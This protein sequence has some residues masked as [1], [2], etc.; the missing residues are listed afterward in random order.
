M[1]PTNAIPHPLRINPHVF[2]FSQRVTD[3][4]RATP[5]N[6]AARN[7]HVNFIV[8]NEVRSNRQIGT[9]LFNPFFR[10]IPVSLGGMSD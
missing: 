3:H 8:G 2:Q 9:P 6:V 4:E 1:S 5:G 7:R 10:V